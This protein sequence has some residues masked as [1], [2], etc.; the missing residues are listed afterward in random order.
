MHALRPHA[1]A[2][3]RRRVGVLEPDRAP[4]G[5]NTTEGLRRAQFV[6]AQE[7]AVGIKVVIDSVDT[8][9]TVA[10]RTSGN[11]DA[12][13]GGLTPGGLDPTNTIRLASWDVANYPGYSNPQLDL[14]L[15]GTG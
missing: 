11:F 10:R 15:C 12:Y 8:A 4:A 3:A 1:C 9:T 7:E 2:E 13:F 5:G 14:I 6:Q